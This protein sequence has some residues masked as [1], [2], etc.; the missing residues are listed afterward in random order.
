MKFFFSSII[1]IAFMLQ[2][3]S[4]KSDIEANHDTETILKKYTINFDGENAYG[5]LDTPWRPT[6][7]NWEIEIDLAWDSS[8]GANTYPIA[9]PSSNT[10]IYIDTA[11]L[12]LFKY[13]GQ[14]I[15]ANVSRLVNGER[16]TIK[17]SVSS[18]EVK[19][20]M[21]GVL[22]GTVATTK[23]LLNDW[24]VIGAHGSVALNFKGKIYG[25]KL[26]DL[27]D[28]TNSREINFVVEA[29][30]IDDISKS[31]IESSNGTSFTYSAD[32]EFVEI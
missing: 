7:V 1:G 22:E 27:D 21:N 20:Y 30:D 14:Y 26:N 6:G 8:K 31:D 3:T 19:H 29:G 12:P 23:S 13:E 5:T 17:F 4:C 25:I 24:E 15:S 11:G 9:T 18:S 2:M 32:G 10:S 28:T 16:S